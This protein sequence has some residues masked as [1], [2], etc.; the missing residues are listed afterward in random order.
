MPPKVRWRPWL[1]DPFAAH[2]NHAL[3]GLANGMVTVEDLDLA[4]FDKLVAA[5]MPVCR[6]GPSVIA[7]FDAFCTETLLVLRNDVPSALRLLAE[8]A[9]VATSLR[10]D[11]QWDGKDLD[12]V[13]VEAAFAYLRRDDVSVALPA[14]PLGP[15]GKVALRAV[16]AWL[17]SNTP[18]DPEAPLPVRRPEQKRAPAPSRWQVEAGKML[19][20]IEREKA[21]ALAANEPPRLIPRSVSR[22]YWGSNAVVEG[23][24]PWPV[25]VS[26]DEG[27]EGDD[28][29][30]V[31]LKTP[32]LRVDFVAEAA[33]TVS[34]ED[35][36]ALVPGCPRKKDDDP[37]ISSTTTKDSDHPSAAVP[38]RP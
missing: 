1:P 2:L 25:R 35:S 15:K 31:L 26:D 23:N 11:R 10:T 8:V 5:Q 13:H 12:H 7:V 6:D 34:T 19:E 22:L 28:D 16:A 33:K 3:S 4:G 30:D 36:N 18:R 38:E 37:S 17:R 21:E 20:R 24:D 32:L 9:Y 27:D 14:L 29:C